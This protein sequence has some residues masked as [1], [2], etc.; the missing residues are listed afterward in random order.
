M[1][2]QN[3]SS[4]KAV[5][6]VML[7]GGTTKSTVTANTAE[8]LGRAG[9]DVLA[10][11]TDPN[12]HLTENLGFG[13]LYYDADFDLGDVILSSGT[14]APDDVIQS[15][16]LG[17]D[18]LPASTTLEHVE[19][20]LKD[21]MQPSLCLKQRLVDPLLGTEYDYILIDTHSSR[22]ALVNNAVVAAPNLFLPLIPEQGIISGLSRTRERVIAP[23]REKIELDILALAPN[24]LS[25]RIDHH[26]ED[27]ALIERICRS[28]AL[29]QYVPQFAYIEPDTFDVI[30]AGE[31]EG[32][33]PKPGLR[34]DADLNDSFKEG[35]T[36][37]AYNPENPHLDA[38]DELAD[39]IVRGKVVR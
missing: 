36:L 1:S 28:E 8:A 26:N 18:L 35:K 20:R 22:N 38:F 21:E 2:P 5:A 39:I 37:G 11:D 24:K 7:K 25:H 27:R 19:S 32:D 23:L 17:F 33:L 29:S 31:W 6:T 16:E 4:P 14:A 15:T 9:H 30:D 13:D 10:V 3:T 34:K 12:G